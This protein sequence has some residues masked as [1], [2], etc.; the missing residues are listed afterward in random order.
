M[1]KD[2]QVL[3]REFWDIGHLQVLPCWTLVIFPAPCLHLESD[4]EIDGKN[5]YTILQ[6]NGVPLHDYVGIQVQAHP[7]VDSAVIPGIENDGEGPR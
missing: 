5:N 1:G 2:V 7:P 6:K 4:E 3:Q